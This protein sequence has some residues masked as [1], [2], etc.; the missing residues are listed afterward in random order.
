M[1]EQTKITVEYNA[2]AFE[3]K[4]KIT[5]SEADADLVRHDNGPTIR[6]FGER[7]N[8]SDWG[9]QIRGEVT[10]YKIL[11]ASFDGG[12]NELKTLAKEYIEKQVDALKTIRKYWESLEIPVDEVHYCP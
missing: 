2:K 3:C 11:S 7:A 1:T 4:V 10:S 12:Y 8:A 5:L 6:F 9:Y